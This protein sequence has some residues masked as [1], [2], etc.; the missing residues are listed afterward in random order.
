[1]SYFTRLHVTIQLDDGARLKHIATVLGV[2][3]MPER[4]DTQKRVRL[5][6]FGMVDLSEGAGYWSF[7]A[8]AI[9]VVPLYVKV[10]SDEEARELMASI[11]KQSFWTVKWVDAEL[12]AEEPAAV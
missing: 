1:M 4:L 11:N 6:D 10:G 2:C 12:L 8:C 9:W 7:H 5:F 3:D